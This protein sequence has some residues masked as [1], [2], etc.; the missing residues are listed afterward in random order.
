MC[1]LRRTLLVFV[2]FFTYA[3][4]TNGRMNTDRPLF[5][6]IIHMTQYTNRNNSND[7]VEPIQCKCYFDNLYILL[8]DDSAHQLS[9]TSFRSLQIHSHPMPE[10]GTY[11]MGMYPMRMQPSGFI[12]MRN[13]LIL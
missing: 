3:P 13:D 1:T 9:M 8:I 6:Q 2:K 10:L 12:C 5:P 7:N 11:L 4:K